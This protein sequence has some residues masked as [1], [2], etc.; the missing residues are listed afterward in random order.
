MITSSENIIDSYKGKKMLDLAKKLYPLNRSIMGPDIRKSFEIISN[1]HPEFKPIKFKTGQKVFDWEVPKEW[2]IR[3]AYIEH[4]SG[5]RFAEFKKNNLHVVGYSIP[6]N[7]TLSK[8]ELIKNLHS[9]PNK[10]NSIPYITSY[11]KEYWGFCLKHEILKNLPEGNYKVVIDS[12]HNPGE[13]WM[14]EALIPGKSS[15]EIFFSSYLC[16]PSMANNELSGPVVLQELLGYVKNLQ[17][18]K[19]SYKFLIGPET[20][21]SIAYLSKNLKHLKEKML[22]GINL[23]CVGDERAFSHVFSRNQDSLADLALSSSLIGL[24]NVKNYSFLDRG[25]DE[26]QYCSPGVDLPVCTFCRSKFGTFP[27]YHSSSDNFNLVTC[28]GLQDSFKVLKTIVDSFEIG[29]IPKLKT[30]CEPNLGSRGLYPTLSKADE[31]GHIG[32]LRLDILS[33]CDTKK[34]LFQISKKLD[35]KL[36]FLL[37]QIKLFK[38]NNLIELIDLV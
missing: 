34:N 9:L 13:L 2:V 15:K 17:D 31:Y 5:K 23:S 22:C 18:R 35:I 36:S 4:E 32:K 6:I 20:I 16:H 19:Y 7:K 27:E 11:Y 14:I 29:L 24:E 30:F 28:K 37:E 38:K 8:K 10:P 25:S 33:F 12:E 26:R 3:D 21:G 1:L